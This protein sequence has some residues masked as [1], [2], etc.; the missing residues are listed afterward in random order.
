MWESRTPG[1]MITGGSR[2]L[3]HIDILGVW[4]L[5][6]AKYYSII[7][8]VSCLWGSKYQPPAQGPQMVAQCILQNTHCVVSTKF[9]A[10][11]S[12]PSKPNEVICGT[13]YGL[14]FSQWLQ[15]IFASISDQTLTSYDVCRT[16][17]NNSTRCASW[18]LVTATVEQTI[19]AAGS[20]NNNYN[21][22]R[23]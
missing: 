12:H 18:R 11:C 10:K 16:W 14:D 6:I 1:Y 20:K 21:Y 22:C 2:H 3:Q 5:N 7:Y 8:P 4:P 19:C 9:T 13:L 17:K 15:D 23:Y